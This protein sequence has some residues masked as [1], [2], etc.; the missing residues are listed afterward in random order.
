M[1]PMVTTK[2]RGWNSGKRIDLSSE[3]YFQVT[4][5]RCQEKFVDNN[6]TVWLIQD[7]I[8]RDEFNGDEGEVVKYILCAHTQSS[9]NYCLD[10]LEK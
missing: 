5:M 2:I 9:P 7:I 6:N 3:L 10:H 8:I 4:K 1:N